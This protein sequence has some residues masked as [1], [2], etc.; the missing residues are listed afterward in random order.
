MVN[1]FSQYELTHW[2]R[3]YLSTYKTDGVGLENVLVV[4]EFNNLT[5]CH[6]EEQN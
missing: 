4:Q 3:R 1:S 2:M 5:L 6:S